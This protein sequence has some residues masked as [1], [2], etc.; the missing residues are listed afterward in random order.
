MRN[1]QMI[2]EE[3]ES[4]NC[5]HSRSDMRVEGSSNEWPHAR[6]PLLVTNIS[7]LNLLSPS[8]QQEAAGRLAE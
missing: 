6:S 4:L 5:V 8:R 2:K 3:F 7:A 1:V